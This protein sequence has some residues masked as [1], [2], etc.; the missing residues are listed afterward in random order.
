A[1]TLS[2]MQPVEYVG[3]HKRV[4]AILGPPPPPAVAVLK[5]LNPSES[6]GGHALQLLRVEYRIESCFGQVG[7]LKHARSPG[8]V[9][10]G[11]VLN[12]RTLPDADGTFLE[13]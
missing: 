11:A 7:R 12:L 13:Q 4:A 3:R 6:V 2:K 8:R 5:L 10:V 9:C 1:G